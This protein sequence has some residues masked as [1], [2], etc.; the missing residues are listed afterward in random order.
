MRRQ[1]TEPA[2]VIAQAEPPTAV[3]ADDARAAAPAPAARPSIR[4][5]G[6]GPARRGKPV[7]AEPDPEP[8]PPAADAGS[9]DYWDAQGGQYAGLVYAARD[10]RRGRQTR[11]AEADARP[12]AAAPG[13][14]NR[15][16]RP[17][18]RDGAVRLG[19]PA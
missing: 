17:A 12:R 14:G 1:A 10:E 2:A 18:L 3:A 13:P 7:T 16:R 4:Y 6:S 8:A 19:S 5:A 15:R 9:A 11:T